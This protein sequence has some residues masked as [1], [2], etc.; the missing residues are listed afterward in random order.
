M[1]VAV[2]PEL[3]LQG[4]MAICRQIQTQIRDHI[5]LGALAPG[6]QLPSIRALAVELAVNPAAVR[7]AYEDLESEGFVT[8]QEGSGT[9]VAAP[10]LGYQPKTEFQEEVE[11]LCMSYLAQ[12]ARFGY[13][14]ADLVGIICS[15]REQG[16]QT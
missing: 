13:T 5:V 7:D 2:D 9:Y 16:D 8:S 12:A 3:T 11:R 1:T 15:F 14:S 4:G 6:E 10:P